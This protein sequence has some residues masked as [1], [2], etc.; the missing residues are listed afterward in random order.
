M[1]RKRGGYPLLVNLYCTNSVPLLDQLWTFG[2]PIVYLPLD[3]KVYFWNGLECGWVGATY[4]V[5]ANLIPSHYPITLPYA[6]FTVVFMQH[7][8]YLW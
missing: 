8:L 1:V 3:S 4:I 6:L 5:L 2:I 7:L